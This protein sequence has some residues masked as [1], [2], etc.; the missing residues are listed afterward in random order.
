VNNMKKLALIL[1]MLLLI[2]G[3]AATTV[4]LEA[5]RQEV[6]INESIGFHLEIYPD[7]PVG[8]A[9]S[10]Y[11]EIEPNRFV[12]VRILYSKPSP[13][14][15][16]TCAGTGPL[17]EDLSRNFYFFPKDGGNYYAEAN[18]GGEQKK[19]G[20]TVLGEETTS[21]TSS[22]STIATSSTTIVITSIPATTTT[23]TSTSIPTTTLR[24]TT[25]TI[26]GKDRGFIESIIDLIYDIIQ[27]LV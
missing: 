11:R 17:T 6:S 20:F 23:T 8:G 7:E 15:C 1:G 24:E 12:I 10:V 27:G 13:G 5:D 25:S 4:N 3:I 14:Q 2:Q 16:Y 18:F 26:S 22:T 21:T 9:L 19:V